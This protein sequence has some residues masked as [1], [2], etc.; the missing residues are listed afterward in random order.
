[1]HFQIKKKRWV[2]HKSKLFYKGDIAMSYLNMIIFEE[3]TL[4]E[5]EQVEEY[6]AR[7]AKE[8]SDKAKAAED[9][10]QR[11]YGERDNTTTLRGDDMKPN[12][13]NDRYTT[14]TVNNLK[15]RDSK[16][17]SADQKQNHFDKMEAN[18]KKA[19][20]AAAKEA[21]RRE[22]NK[23]WNSGNN[24]D[25]MRTKSNMSSAADAISRH[26]RRHPNAKVE[27]VIELAESL[28]ESYQPDCI[29][30]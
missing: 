29:F 16:K 26:N 18:D 2:G 8:A 9:K 24:N 14:G 7:K 27:S 19:H 13:S 11:R 17:L 21:N 15:V 3:S 1:M 6:K 23:F 5:G 22:F 28:L 12:T 4:L 10:Y 20:I 30:C 25:A